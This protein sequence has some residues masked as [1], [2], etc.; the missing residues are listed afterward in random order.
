M[1]GLRIVG[2]IVFGMGRVSAGKFFVFNFIG[3]CIWAIL[4]VGVGFLFGQGLELMLT[5]AKHF[6]MAGLGAIALIGTV[7]WA[8]RRCRRT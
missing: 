7:L 4:V 1:Y 2:P 5:D 3:A 8:V 6:A